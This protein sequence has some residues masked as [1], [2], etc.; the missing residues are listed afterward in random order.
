MSCRRK[1]MLWSK[2]SSL[3]GDVPPIALD[4]PPNSQG[5]Y[6]TE[7]PRVSPASR[8][9]QPVPFMYSTA[10]FGAHKHFYR[11]HLRKRATIMHWRMNQQEGVTEA[12]KMM[13]PR[14]QL[15]GDMSQVADA[16]V[17]DLDG[18]GRAYNRRD[19]QELFSLPDAS[20]TSTGDSDESDE[21]LPSVLHVEMPTKSPGMVPV[22]YSRALNNRIKEH[23][24]SEG[25][26]YDILK[27]KPTFIHD[28]FMA[29][30]S[31]SNL[32]GKSKSHNMLRHPISSRSANDYRLSRRL[33]QKND[34]RSTRWLPPPRA[35]YHS[36]A[37]RAEIIQST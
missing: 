14:K 29:P 36:P 9:A 12:Q 27:Y 34:A 13:H 16:L 23:M 32:L 2:S 37:M 4:L 3:L 24:I 26:S 22:A 28:V 18:N 33:H 35:A 8:V 11:N 15:S 1:G 7:R 30:G 17:P 19:Y 20:E 6:V 21:S 5:P 10:C 31:L 25:G